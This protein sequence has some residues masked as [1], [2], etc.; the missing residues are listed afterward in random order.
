MEKIKEFFGNF[1][2][3]TFILLNFVRRTSIFQIEV[4]K[5]EVLRPTLHMLPWLFGL[6]DVFGPN[7]GKKKEPTYVY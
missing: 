7:G 4:L 5:S 6:F 3:K 2:R 1:V